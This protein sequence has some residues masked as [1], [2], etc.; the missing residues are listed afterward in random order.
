MGTKGR[1]AA[2]WLTFTFAAVSLSSGS[3]AAFYAAVFFGLAFFRH[4]LWEVP[5]AEKLDYVLLLPVNRHWAG[6]MAGRRI[7]GQWDRAFEIH[8]LYRAGVDLR[9]Q[10]DGVLRDLMFIRENRPGLYLWETATSVPGPV[11]KLIGEKAKQGHSFW[12]KGCF[13][14]RFPL[15]YGKTGKRLR[16]GALLIT[17][18]RQA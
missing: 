1:D 12:S 7:R 10:R 3:R 2:L 14:P 13:L 15:T 8:I 9:E 4:H 6:F 18:E 16:Y 11:R 17:R 5:R